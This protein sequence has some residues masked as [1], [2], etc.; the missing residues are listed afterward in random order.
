MQVSPLRDL[1]FVRRLNTTVSKGGIVLTEPDRTNL[2][3]VLATGPE[4]TLKIGDRVILGHRWCEAKLNGEDVLVF[5]E[6]P[7]IYAVVPA[8]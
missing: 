4:A 7:D 8:E 6:D 1:V 2:G 3:E 5:K